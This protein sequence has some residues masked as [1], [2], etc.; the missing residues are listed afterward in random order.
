MRTHHGFYFNSI[1]KE[2]NQHKEIEDLANDAI[3]N[4]NQH[5]I[6]VVNQ[7]VLPQ[8]LRTKSEER[9][10]RELVL[11]KLCILNSWSLM[12]ISNKA[13]SKFF[14]DFHG[15]AIPN[16]KRLTTL[17]L[18]SLFSITRNEVCS[19]LKNIPAVNLT[20]DGWSGPSLNHFVG[21]TCHFLD[22]KWTLRRALLGFKFVPGSQDASNIKNCLQDTFGSILAQNKM[23]FTIVSDRGS[24]IKKATRNLTGQAFYIAHLIN[25]MVVKAIGNSAGCTQLS[26][27]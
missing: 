17:L 18:A 27:E 24:N 8:F 9:M 15:T 7:S 20:S 13:T 4:A 11:L 19:V 5:S 23:V 2:W 26:T 10:E 14:L 21:V 22:A 6:S 3:R 1:E 25:N 12:S 16:R